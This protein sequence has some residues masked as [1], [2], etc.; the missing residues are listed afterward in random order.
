MAKA[1]SRRWASSSKYPRTARVNEVLRE[2]IAEELE[3]L[4]D[5]D[6]RL[7]LVTITGVETD[8]DL[9]RATVY[10]SALGTKATTDEVTA[11]LDEQRV[12][13]QSAIGRSVRLKRTPLLRFLP[14]LGIIE[15]QKVESILRTLPPPSSDDEDS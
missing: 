9:G 1:G 15:G 4:V 13:M 3:R 8:A 10:F 6:S 7:D 2:V 12:A 11:A 14:D 5:E